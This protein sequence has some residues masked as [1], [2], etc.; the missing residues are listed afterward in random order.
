MDIDL[1]QFIR[2]GDGVLW[3]QACG[4][5]LT[6]TEAFVAQRE[7][8]SG[9]SAFL[10]VNFA[11]T[12]KAV[13]A[14]HLR[15]TAY[16][17]AGH[18]RKLADAGVLDI[19][20]FAYSQLGELIRSG[21]L[22]A[23]V[24]LLQVS[25]PNQR[26]EYS[27]GLTVEYL[28]PALAAARCVIAEV[29]DQVPWTHTDPVLKAEDFAAVVHSS[30]PLVPLPEGAPGETEFTIGRNA[31][32]FIPD[33]SVLEFGL[34]SLP[35]A[36]L[37]ALGGR[38]DLG[39]HSGLICDGVA[40]LMRS[41][42]ITNAHKNID[43]GISVA[44]VLMGTQLLFDFARDNPA[45]N[46]RS[47]DYTHNARVLGSIERFVAINSAV[48][49]DLTGQVNAEI[50]AG[51]Y[52]GAVGGALDFI[53]AANASPGGASLICLPASIGTKVSRIV[54]KLSGPVAT[55][56]SEAGVFVTEYGSAD[57]RGVP[58]SR[59]VPKMIAIAHPAFRGSLERE[60]RAATL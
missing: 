23:D 57:L 20:P 44:G 30:R 31:A 21:R 8:Y 51:S 1:A 55:P 41:G 12:V 38:R 2:P 14:D 4:E 18:N 6:L 48:E 37:A 27:L 7:R 19:C 10:G 25:P 3:P 43:R 60:A 13:H 47:S 17:G 59:R 9:A 28:G 50:A 36:I 15:L 54:A 33:R 46:L 40:K 58:L 35:D 45:I 22:K 49:V 5:P 52:V 24:L 16:C 34:G 32:E 42:A 39:V 56:R 26:G 53:R 29:N 11:A